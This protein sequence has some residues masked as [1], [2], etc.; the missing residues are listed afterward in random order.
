MGG[1]MAL[2]IAFHHP[3]LFSKVGAYSPSILANDFS[4]RQLESWLYPNDNIKKFSNV[5]KF[6][7]KKGFTHLHIYVDA[8]KTNDPF[9][10]GVQS[11]YKAL[12][13]RNISSE[14]LIYDGGHSL[15][16]NLVKDYL[17]FY[18]GAK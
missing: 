4:D 17:R 7:K 10:V 15:Q 14:L 1:M 6:A 5:K 9:L 13:L 16:I 3:N 8:G 12:Q 18:T 2:R 11:L